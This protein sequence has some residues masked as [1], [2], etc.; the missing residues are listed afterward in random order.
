MRSLRTLPLTL[1]LIL[2]LPTFG[3]AFI[4]FDGVDGEVMAAGHEKWIELTSLQNEDGTPVTAMLDQGR[5]RISSSSLVTQLDRLC[6]SRASLG[7]VLVDIDGTRHILRNARFTECPKTRGAV[8]TAV[9]EFGTP[10]ASL[11][12]GASASTA[13]RGNATLSR[14][15]RTPFDMDIRRATLNGNVATIALKAGT[16]SESL[17]KAITEAT[18]KGTVYPV[19]GIESAGQQWSFTKVMFTSASYSQTQDM[20]FSFQFETMNG[21]AAAFQALGN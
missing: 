6:Q 17:A 13:Q 10:T 18:A 12:R 20:L 4:K 19:I 14:L 1:F 16:V 11:K 8:R 3:A 9:L 21:S 2:A 7:N 5:V 15:G